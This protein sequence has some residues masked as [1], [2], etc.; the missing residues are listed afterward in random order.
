MT[1]KDT[2]KQRR[3]RWLAG[4]GMSILVLAV[5]ILT[6]RQTG[7]HQVGAAPN[8]QAANS[9]PIEAS[10]IIEAEEVSIASELGGLIAE[11][12][13][14]EGSSVSGGDLLVQLDTAVLDAQIE[15]AEAMI[16]IAEAGLAQAQA[17]TR[18]GQIITAEAN[19]YP[20]TSSGR[21]GCQQTSMMP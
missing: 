9:A 10:G 16:A 4:I 1:G 13:V 15:V 17:G 21:W 2:K 14:V 3:P 12:P 18:P 8:L 20:G 11:I 6:T 7:A 19:R 5:A